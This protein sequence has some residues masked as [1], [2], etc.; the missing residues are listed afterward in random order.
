MGW[1]YTSKRPWARAVRIRP[2][3]ANCSCMS[4]RRP[5]SGEKTDTRFRPPSLLWYMA[6]SAAASTSSGVNPWAG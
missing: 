4:K 2:A 3:H 5:S 1:A 6:V